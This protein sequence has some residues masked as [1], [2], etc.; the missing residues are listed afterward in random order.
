VENPD[1]F[2]LWG[3]PVFSTKG[4]KGRPPFRPT[5]ENVNR[6]NML[7]AAGWTNERIASTILDAR[8]GKAISLPTLHRYFRDALKERFVAR[9]RMVARQMER[10]WAQAEKGNLGA[11]KL[12]R[13]MFEDEMRAAA[14]DRARKGGETDDFA[15]PE[16]NSAKGKKL[17]RAD[18]AVALFQGSSLLNPGA[19]H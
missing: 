5:V 2:D 13:T 14:A 8:T 19:A 10:V 17:A 18:D 7:L 9:D 12:L 15:P 16:K 11:E 3:N 1:S 4:K 6:V